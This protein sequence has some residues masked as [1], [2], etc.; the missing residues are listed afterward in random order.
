MTI[1]FQRT[2]T[3][4]SNPN[5]E[6]ASHEISQLTRI[7]SHIGTIRVGGRWVVERESLACRHG[8]K[9]GAGGGGAK[10]GSLLNR[11]ENA[12]AINPQRLDLQQRARARIFLAVT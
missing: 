7:R 4:S 3:S 11:R 6:K 9:R 8:E 10:W 5:R 1:S 12:S 2:S